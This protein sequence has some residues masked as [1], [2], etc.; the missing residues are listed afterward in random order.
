M[1]GKWILAF[2]LSAVLSLPALATAEELVHVVKEENARE[3]TLY[4]RN[5]RP[6]DVTISFKFTWENAE[7]DQDCAAFVVR[8]NELVRVCRITSRIRNMP[9]RY[10]FEWRYKLGNMTARHDDAFIYR[11]PF[12]EGKRVVVTQGFGGKFSHHGGS[13]YSIDW[14]VPEGTPI[15]ASREGTVVAVES[16]HSEGGPTPE[17]KEKANYVIVLHEDGTLGQYLHLEKD[18]VA[19]RVGERILEGGLIGYS[20]N[21]GFSTVPHL[22]FNVYKPKDGLETESIP[23]RFKTGEGAGIALEQGKEY[24]VSR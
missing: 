21:T 18:G 17:F 8:P 15:H 19:V 10:S 24:T 7:V 3:A 4:V 5:G 1:K 2:C 20:G 13:R 9:W 22:H 23:I 11:L 16:Q 12:E 14:R 6:V